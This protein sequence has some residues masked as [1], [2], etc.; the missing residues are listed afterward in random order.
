MSLEFTEVKDIISAIK[1]VPDFKYQKDENS[2]YLFGEE[3]KTAALEWLSRYYDVTNPA[4]HVSDERAE[5][6]HLKWIDNDETMPELKRIGYDMTFDDQGRARA[7]IVLRND[8]NEAVGGVQ[9]TPTELMKLSRYC[10]SHATLKLRSD[11][12]NPDDAEPVSYVL[13]HVKEFLKDAQD[14]CPE[15]LTALVDEAAKASVAEK[16]A[17]NAMVIAT[18]KAQQELKAI[19]AKWAKHVVALAQAC[20][21]ESDSARDKQLSDPLLQDAITKAVDLVAH[22]NG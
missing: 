22:S 18:A 13:H 10:F 7:T 15:V 11:V 2:D 12:Y 4:F 16:A 8:A 6:G 21:K 1:N 3:A 17:E 19:E 20:S 9:L 14:N 5:R